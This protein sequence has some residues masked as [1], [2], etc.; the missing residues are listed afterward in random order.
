MPCLFVVAALAAPRMIVVLLWLFTSWFR[1]MFSIA[2]WPVLGFLFRD[3]PLED[4]AAFVPK[5]TSAAEVVVVLEK[6]GRYQEA[7][8]L[9]T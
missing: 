9:L 8:D 5:K 3:P 4:A 7:P 1:G 2:L 6:L